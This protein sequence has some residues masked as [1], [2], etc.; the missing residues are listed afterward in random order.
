M[1]KYTETVEEAE[2]VLRRDL[3]S[4]LNTH[5]CENESNTPDFVLAQYLI[6]SLDAF[7]NAINM[8]EA[9]FGRRANLGDA[10]EA[11]SGLPIEGPVPRP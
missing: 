1:G 6:L 2:S 5:S 10:V 3:A 8:R 9:W 11:D 7:D 4:L